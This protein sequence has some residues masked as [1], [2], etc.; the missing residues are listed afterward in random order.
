MGETRKILEDIFDGKIPVVRTDPKTGEEEHVYV[1]YDKKEGVPKEWYSIRPHT[2]ALKDIADIAAAIGKGGAYAGSRALNFYTLGASDWLEKKLTGGNSEFERMSKEVKDNATSP[3]GVAG[4]IANGI[5]N[6]GLVAAELGG[7]INGAGKLTYDLA[8]KG[9]SGLGT[10]LKSGKLAKSALAPA[11]FSGGTDAGIYSAFNN[12]FSN[13]E[14]VWNDTR[15]GMYWGAGFGA[16]GKVLSPVSKLFSAKSMTKGMKGGLEN[17]ADNPEAVKILN[18]GIRQNNDVA[19]E[20]LNKLPGATRQINAEV[21]DTLNTS[22][23]RRIDIPQTI[24]CQKTKYDKFMQEHAGDSVIDFAPRQQ[25]STIVAE[26][27]YNP[28]LGRSK[29]EYERMIKDRAAEAKVELSDDTEHFLRPER[30]QY[31][32]TLKNT[33][34]KPDISYTQ[35][36]PANFRQNYFAK[37]YINNRTGEP[38]FDLAFTR[39]GRVFNKF[40]TDENYIANQF[41]KPI[42]DLSLNGYVSGNRADKLHPDII[43]S[44]TQNGAVVNPQLP[45]V[46]TLYE[47]LTPYQ[48]QQLNKAVAAGIAK[49]NQPAGSLES[50]HLIRRK[51]SD[52]AAQ[53]ADITEKAALSELE[54]RFNN[55]LGPS[56]RSYVKNYDKA[57]DLEKAFAAGQSVPNTKKM[58]YGQFMQEHAADEVLNFAPTREQLKAIKPQSKYNPNKNLAREEAETLL[59]NRTTKQNLGIYNDD[60]SYAPNAVEDRLG[61]QHLLDIGKRPFIRTLNNTENYPDINFSANGRKFTAKMYNNTASNKD[62]IDW[63]ITEN[64]KIVTKYPTDANHV[65]REINKSAQNMS[66]SERVPL[67]RTGATYTQLPN[68][69]NN[70]IPHRRIIVNPELPHMSSLYEGLAPYQTQQLNKA[71]AAGIAKSNQPAGSLE[72]L[73]LIRRKISDSAAQTADI[74]E[75]AALSELEKRLDNLLNSPYQAYEENFAKVLNGENISQYP[76]LQRQAY[77]QGIFNQITANSAQKNNLAQEALKYNRILNQVISPSAVTPLHETLNRRASGFNRLSELEHTAE[78]RLTIKDGEQ[79]NL[80]KQFLRRRPLRQASQNLMD[81][82]F[83]GTN[84][85]WLMENYPYIANYFSTV[86]PQTQ[87]K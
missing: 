36:N 44:I 8:A 19:Q 76:P 49:S 21:S 30:K 57:Q 51:I 2:N 38:F 64:G 11:I 82:E 48:T 35:I 63:I 39:N 10:V 62:F 61:I 46:S 81:P 3:G 42:Q 77:A 84:D 85:N 13:P 65:V 33:L 15:H 4:T 56:Y 75:K 68:E 9:I 50:L 16:V 58:E 70:C 55:L 1:Y 71:V 23:T 60:L 78:H 74:T 53:T 40:N 47:G 29:G 59:R 20:Y 34:E 72:S 28:S 43:N 52:S 32:R 86:A 18:S 37:K 83:V 22:L 87:N 27:G 12:D 80:W 26:S 41:K 14:T 79:E 67:G 5:T 6:A 73:H 45:N 54:K 66:L 17:V 25:I 31:I 7:G 24:A 69:T